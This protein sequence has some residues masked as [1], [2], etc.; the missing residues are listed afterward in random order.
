MGASHALTD[1]FHTAVY[2]GDH[3]AGND[4]LLFEQ[5]HLA[6][7]HH[8]NEGIFV[9]L[10]GKQSGN[11]GHENQLAGFE[12]GGDLRRSGI[13]VDIVHLAAVAAGNG[14]DDRGVALVNRVLNHACV[15]LYDLSHK[16]EIILLHQLFRHEHTPVQTAES[17]RLAAVLHE[18]LHQTLVD[19]SGENHLHNVHGFVI[20]VA[21][22]IDEFALLADLVEHGVDFRTAAVN[23][24]GV[25]TNQLQQ[26]NVAHDRLL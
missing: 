7:I 3:A 18:V 20:G 13:G 5:R 14:A 15:D 2:L 4:A 21:H 26:Y 19:L 25:D 6:D 17:Q 22:A 1:G 10:I 24:H 16:A 8:R 23:Q 12:L 11:V 9:V